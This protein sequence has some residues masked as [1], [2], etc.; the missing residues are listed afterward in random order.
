MA[1]NASLTCTSVLSPH[2]STGLWCFCLPLCNISAK[3]SLNSSRHAVSACTVVYMFVP[4]SPS[5]PLYFCWGKKVK[6]NGKEN[7]EKV[8]P[9]CL[10]KLSFH[11]ISF[12]MWNTERSS[13]RLRTWRKE[14]LFCKQ[15]IRMHTVK[16]ANVLLVYTTNL[17]FFWLIC[18]LKQHSDNFSDEKLSFAAGPVA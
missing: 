8:L 13:F 17:F 4:V 14:E 7:K 9:G 15:K 11:A 3:S 2:I 16:E 5:W 10:N 1:Q 12:E 6:K 18:L